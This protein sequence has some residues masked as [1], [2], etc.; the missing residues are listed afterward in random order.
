MQIKALV[1]YR[2][3]ATGDNYLISEAIPGPGKKTTHGR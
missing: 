1:A 3:A 2:L